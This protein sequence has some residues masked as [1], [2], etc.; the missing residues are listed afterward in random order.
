M[1]GSRAPRD[2]GRKYNAGILGA[3]GNLHKVREFVWAV[4]GG[5][6]M[7]RFNGRVTHG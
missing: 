5:W 3:W 7:A 4:L 6:P 2:T 1:G